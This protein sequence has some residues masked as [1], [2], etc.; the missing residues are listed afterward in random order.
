MIK[1][2]CSICGCLKF[3][4]KPV[5]RQSMISFVLCR[6]INPNQLTVKTGMQ[7]NSSMNP[8][9]LSDKIGIKRADNNPRMVR[10]CF[11]QSDEMLA[12]D[13]Q[14]FHLHKDAPCSG[15]LIFRYLSSD[16]LLMT[17]KVSPCV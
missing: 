4:Q 16:F 9:S 13:C 10:G 15:F 2:Q 5:D 7:F 14:N 6:T 8:I 12:I 17:T 3:Q 1:P 11:M